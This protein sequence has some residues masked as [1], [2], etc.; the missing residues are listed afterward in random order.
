M[1]RIATGRAARAWGEGEERVAGG[2]R[3]G[4]VEVDRGGG[5]WVKGGG[6]GASAG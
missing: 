5:A 2:T 6:G 1:G 3:R 4:M